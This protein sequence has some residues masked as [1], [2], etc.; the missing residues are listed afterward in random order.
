MNRSVFLPISV[1]RLRNG[2]ADGPLSWFLLALLLTAP[3]R[4]RS[5]GRTMRHSLEP[6]CFISF[7]PWQLWSLSPYHLVTYGPADTGTSCLLSG[8]PWF[9]FS[10]FFEKLT[11]SGIWKERKKETTK[12]DLPV[13][14]DKCWMLVP[15][16]F[17]HVF[18]FSSLE[19][20]IPQCVPI[21]HY[22][23]ISM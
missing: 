12:K 10:Y 4:R 11:L 23:F 7:S 20:P 22:S 1:K 15:L 14:G 5:E 21:Y 2:T 17:K 8:G 13:A 19:L 9:S 18:E 16:P 6:A 3:C